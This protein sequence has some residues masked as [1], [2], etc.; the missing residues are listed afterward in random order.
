MSIITNI[1]LKE[2]KAKAARILRNI[3][4]L[5][6]STGCLSSDEDSWALKQEG[7]TSPKCRITSLQESGKRDVC[8]FFY[9]Q[10]VHEVDIGFNLKII[11]LFQLAELRRKLKTSSGK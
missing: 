8:I 9:S 3:I 11:S 4:E 10:M 7:K 6:E 1:R 2:L 5:N